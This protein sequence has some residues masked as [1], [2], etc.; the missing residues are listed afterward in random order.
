MSPPTLN[1]HTAGMPYPPHTLQVQ[2]NISTVLA[3][4]NE[5]LRRKL[6]AL[7]QDP[8]KVMQGVMHGAWSMAVGMMLGWGMGQGVTAFQ[9]FGCMP[10]D[11]IPNPN[12]PPLPAIDR[13]LLATLGLR[14]RDAP[15]LWR[16]LHPGWMPLSP[17]PALQRLPPGGCS[18]RMSCWGGRTAAVHGAG[19][20]RALRPCSGT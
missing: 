17:L 16:R 1:V 15:P 2:R 14:A 9:Y 5:R 3:D 4:E 13:Y 8:F 6:E 18:G 11:G 20:R 7:S 10:A 12:L 19:A